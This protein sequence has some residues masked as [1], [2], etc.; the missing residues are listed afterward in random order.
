M[1]N[2]KITLIEGDGIGPEVTK[3]AKEVLDFLVEDISWQ[4]VIAGSKAL[5][6]TGELVPI[7]VFDS[8]EKTKRILKGPIATPIGKGFRSVNVYLRKHF[9]LYANVRPA[10]SFEGVPS[11]Y[12]AVDLV[13]FRENT[14]G[15]YVGIEE[16]V[17]EDTRHSIKVITR[18]G[19]ERI[20]RAA[21]DYARAQNRKK[22]TLAHKANILK[23]TD[24]LFLEIGRKISQS[25]PDIE[26]EEMIIDNLCMQLVIDPTQFDVFVTMNLYGDILSDLCAGLVGGLGLTASAN[27]GNGY[28]L[29][30][31]VHGSAPD[32]AGKNLANPTAMLLSA[33]MLLKH[34]GETDKGEKLEKAIELLLKNPENHTK[35]LGGMLTTTDFTKRVIE[36]LASEVK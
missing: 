31:P 32:I 1:A 15:L 9:D 34:V 6:Q 7:Q 18:H 21:F 3:S 27:I 19:S 10:K 30:E 29:F 4:H 13:I 28:A 22:V 33:A 24:G 5:E 25:Y 17:D 2:I 26:F 14:E 12:K 8:A 35:D 36:V 23:E 16:R 11:R 20:I